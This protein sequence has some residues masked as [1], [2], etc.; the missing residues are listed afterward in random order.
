MNK[1][2][3]PFGIFSQPCFNRIFSNCF[4]HNSPAKGWPYKFRSR[5]TTG[6]SILDHDFGHLCRGRRIQMSGHSDFGIFNNLWASFF[7]FGISWYCTCCLSIATR[8]SGD[9]IHDLSC[10]HLRCWRSLFSEYCIRPW[11][12]FY[13]ITAEHNSTLVFLVL[14]HQ[15]SILHMIY[16]HSWCKMNCSAR[17]SCFIDHLFLTF[18]FRQI[19]RRKFLQFFPFLVHRCFRCWNLHCLRHRNKLVNQI[20]VL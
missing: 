7:Y 12:V 17:R 8:Q 3:F 11:V 16:I 1:E 15:F 18:D 20:I 10:C 9:D 4:S 19:P 2:T 6:S 13:N 5:G 14:C